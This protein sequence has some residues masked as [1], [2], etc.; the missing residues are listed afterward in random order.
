MVEEILNKILDLPEPEIYLR[1]CID[2]DD[3]TN[4]DD[5]KSAAVCA[6]CPIDAKSMIEILFK[7]LKSNNYKT[8][9]NTITVFDFL[10]KYSTEYSTDF[11]ALSCK[12]YKRVC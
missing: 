1:R 9:T 4:L 12:R 6:I 10:L 3:A 11:K 5:M 2:K 7:G 8:F